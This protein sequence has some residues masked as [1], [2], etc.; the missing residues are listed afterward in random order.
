MPS[1]SGREVDAS[2]PLNINIKVTKSDK[3]KAKLKLKMSLHILIDKPVVSGP[4]ETSLIVL[5]YAI[6]RSGL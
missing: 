1:L 6:S 3:S 5:P 4:Y 2:Q